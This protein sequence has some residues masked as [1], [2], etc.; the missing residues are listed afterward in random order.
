MALCLIVLFGTAACSR[1]VNRY[2]LIEDSLMAGNT[3]RADQIVEQAEPDY[4]A[5]SHVLYLMDRGMTLH[6]TGR[7]QASTDMLD[8]AEQEIER[9][10]TRHLRTEAKAFLINDS[11]L[12]YE[13]DPYEQTMINVIKG[14]N[15][16]VQGNWNE[17]V[18]EA[19]RIDHRLNVLGDRVNPKDGYRDDAFARYLSGL[20]FEIAG[21]LNNAFIAYRK[22]Y[23]AYQQAR[24]WARTPVPPSI[25]TDLLRMSQALHLDQEHEQYRREFGELVWQPY[26]D[27]HDLAQVIVVTYNGRAPRKE[28]RLIDLPVSLDALKLVLLTKLPPRAQSQERR[29]LE[30]VLYG[31]NGHVVRVAIPVLVPQKTDVLYAEVT[32][33]DGAHSVQAR[34]Q[35][36][37]NFTAV[38]EKTLADRLPGISV[39][40]VARAAVKY[41]LADGVR[42]GARA[43]GG[44]DKEARLIGFIVGSLAHALAIASEEAD[45]RSWRTLPDEIQIARLWLPPGSYE[46]RTHSVDHNGRRIGHD[47]GY[48]VT[49]HGGETKL[50][51]ERVIP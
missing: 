45:K 11:K 51:T 27:T 18:V 38:A 37:Q 49:L 35:L 34:T 1:T 46:L 31:L 39:K 6:L 16:A 3:Q 25:R 2:A 30:S 4:G 43:A 48:A 23:E 15:Y 28:D 44:K 41:G 10:Y 50:M 12:T 36:V 29:A 5:E 47:S 17:A 14:L 24:P 42:H 21:D 33:A 32:A 13:G 40:A 9:L 22:A 19:R 8:Q 7:Y 26:S 20:F